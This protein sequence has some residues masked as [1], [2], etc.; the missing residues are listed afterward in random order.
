M[1]NWN[2]IMICLGIISIELGVLLFISLNNRITQSC[3]SSD[4]LELI[5]TINGLFS[6]IL[7]TYFFNRISWILDLKKETYE[8]AI[9]FSQKITEFRRICFKLTQYYG[10]WADDNATKSLLEHNEYKYIDYYDFK[11][12]YKSDDKPDKG[13]LQV[14]KEL[15]EDG[16][17]KEGISDLFLGMISLVRHRSSR[18]NERPT[19]LYKDFQKKGVNNFEFIEKS[20]ECNYASTL[21]YWFQKDY[22]FINFDALSKKSREYVLDACSRIDIKYRDSELN[23]ELMA[24]I[25]D[26]MNEHYFKELY[27]LLIILRRGLSKFDLLIFSVLIASLIFGVLLPFAVYFIVEIS[28]LKNILTKILIGVNFSLMFFFITNLYGLV[29]KEIVWR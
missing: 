19:E 12:Y 24:E 17:Y 27:R 28:D 11:G 26:D 9:K 29:R 3:F 14:I 1:K 22:T 13:I 20:V 25:C 15:R 16:R 10:V 8:D 4:S 6:A 5:L 2:W 21:G 18:S 23:N 7:V